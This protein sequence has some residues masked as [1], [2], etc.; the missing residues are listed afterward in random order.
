MKASS[1]AVC[2]RSDPIWVGLWDTTFCSLI[3]F[4]RTPCT[5][6]FQRLPK[7]NQAIQSFECQAQSPQCST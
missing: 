2:F 7:A 4:I 5:N 3:G 6:I 1:H